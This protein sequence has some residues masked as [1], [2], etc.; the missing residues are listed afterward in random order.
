[1]SYLIGIMGDS[2]S[3]KSTST[4]NLDYKTTFYIDSDRK[5]LP[6]RGWRKKYNKE[7]KNYIQT[8]DASLIEKTLNFINKNEDYKHIKTIVIDT[9]NA[10]M[11]DQEMERMKEKG[12]DRWQDLAQEIWSIL[13][14]CLSMRQDLYIICMFHCEDCQ[15]DNGI[16]NY[17]IRTAGRKLQKIQLETRFPILFLAKKDG[18]KYIFET[19]SNFSTAKSPM[20]LFKELKIDNDI[21]YV[22]D[23]LEKYENEEIAL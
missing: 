10:V 9:I 5:G 21:K 15:D 4:R 19:Q 1:M 22:I 20:G 8:S 18:E 16:H 12:Y 17:R 2:G 3:G 14:N 6:F 11:I 23:E 13:S 7:N